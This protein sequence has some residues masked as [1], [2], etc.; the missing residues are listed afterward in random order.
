MD[1]ILLKENALDVL[2]KREESFQNQY[3]PL[4]NGYLKILA[5]IAQKQRLS[6]HRLEQ[7][8]TNLLNNTFSQKN[9]EVVF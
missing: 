9:R 5:A 8:F 6:S 7:I 2:E 3:D 4:M 1:L